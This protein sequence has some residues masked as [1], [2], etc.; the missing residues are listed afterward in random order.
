MFSEGIDALFE[1]TFMVFKKRDRHFAFC[2]VDGKVPG[3]AYRTCPKNFMGS[4]FMPLW[5]R[6]LRHITKRPNG[7]NESFIWT[8]VAVKTTKRRNS[9]AHVQP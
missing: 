5:L 2:G 3:M 4:V 7:G 9:K 8:I 1:H 6:E